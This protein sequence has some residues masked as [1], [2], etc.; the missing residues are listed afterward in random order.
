MFDDILKF[1][2]WYGWQATSH[3]IAGHATDHS[4]NHLGVNLHNQHHSFWDVPHNHIQRSNHLTHNHA[5]AEHNHVQHSNHFTDSHGVKHWDAKEA[6]YGYTQPQT[7]APDPNLYNHADVIGHPVEDAQFWHYQKFNTSCAVVSQLSIVE[8]IY[9]QA[10]LSEYAVCKIA[11]ENHWYDPATGTHID[12]IGEIL[13]YYN[14]PSEHK[15]HASLEDLADALERGDKVIVGLDG[16]DIW[17]PV[18]DPVTG[19]PLPHEPAGH[20]VWVTGIEKEADGSVKI[21]LNDS[22]TPNGRMET[23]DANDFLNA[24]RY[25]DQ[26][27]IVA[28]APSQVVTV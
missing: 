16:K 3:D 6:M 19:N 11:Q 1:G 17:N 12:K 14:V 10:H 5:V 23:V 4:G 21:I 25:S 8:S 7:L 27:M 9:P 2:D 28:H 24:W 15:H 13:N 18:K 22:G 20:A 26:E